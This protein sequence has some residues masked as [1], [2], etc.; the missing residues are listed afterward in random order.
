MTGNIT[1]TGINAL[2][3]KREKSAVI[4]S[5]N[6]EISNYELPVVNHEST[7]HLNVDNWHDNATMNVYHFIFTDL[8]DNGNNP[9]DLNT[10][11]TIDWGN[12]DTLDYTYRFGN[13]SIRVFLEEGTNAHSFTISGITSGKVSIIE[14]FAARQF[15]D[16]HDVDYEEDIDD[17]EPV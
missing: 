10:I 15:G 5:T 16:S 13:V 6:T 1:V 8:I 9:I 11:I 7:I 12:S 3:Y 14:L 4:D 17:I 2:N